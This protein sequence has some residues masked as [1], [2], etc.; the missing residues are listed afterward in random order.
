MSQ[1]NSQVLKKKANNFLIHQDRL[2]RRA[3]KGL[4]L[5]SDILTRSIILQGMHDHIGHWDVKSTYKF[6]A[7]RFWWPKIRAEVSNFVHS[8]EVSQKAKL[9]NQEEFQVRIPI[10]G[11]FST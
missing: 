4:R 6:I 8:C 5:V 1:D 10:S 7:S 3:K 2:F 11:L 9:D